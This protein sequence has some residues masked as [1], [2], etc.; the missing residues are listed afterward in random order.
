[1]KT[2]TCLVLSLAL[3]IQM[4]FSQQN[5]IKTVTSKSGTVLKYHKN[6]G[7]KIIKDGK[8]SFKDLNKNGKLDA[9]EDWRLPVEERAKDLASKMSVEQI[10]GLM[11][12]S[13]HQSIPSGEVGFGAGTYNGKPFSES[14][15]EA[16]A[17]SDQ[18]KQ[19]LKDDNLRHV[20]LTAVKS[21]EVAAKWNNNVQAYVEGLG[22]GI[23]ANN[24]SD[25]RN[26]AE[27][28]SEFNAGAGGTIS[29]WP[30]GLAMGATFDPELVKQF[31]EMASK[32]YRALGITTALSPQVDLGTEPRW[33]RI[34]YVFSESPELVKAMG[35]AYIEGFQTS[36]K[37]SEINSGW[38]YQ[39]VN[40]MVKHWP[41]GGPEE[42]GR[43][44]HWAMGKFAVYPGDNFSDHLKPFTEGAFKLDGGTEKASAVMP[45][46]TISFDRDDVYKENVGN[47]FS[48]YMIT[49]LLRDQYGYDGVVCTDWLITSDEGATPATFAGKPWGTEELSIA[50]RHYKVLK[51]GVD[52]FG[53]NNE[54][55]PVLEA[56]QMGVEEFG[57]DYMRKRFERSAVRLLKNI[58]R[59]GLFEN[60]Y[61]DVE[62]TKAIVG[63]AEFMKAGYK[64]QV[65]SVVMLKNKNQVLPIKEKQTVYIPKIYT[66]VATDWW[67]NAT[68]AH[69]DYPVDIDL[70]KKYYK[71]TEDPKKADFAL[72]FVRNP[73]TKEAGYSEVDR[74]EG[75]NGYVP[76]SLQYETYTATTAREHSIAAGD[77]VIDPEIKDRSYKGKSS[78][79]SYIMD[80]RTI[81]D[82]KMLMGDKPVIVSVTAN[83]PM[84]FSEFES[85][86]DGIVLNF[87]VST[88]AVLDIVSGKDEP[89]GLLPV[90]MPANMET[91]EAQQE[92]VPFDMIPYEDSEGNTYDFGYGLDWN[93]VIKDERVTK[94]KK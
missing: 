31:G 45:Y 34:A 7:V 72:V 3:G 66:P 40:A 87:G 17:I 5:D 36:D 23:P 76:I 49:E 22:L 90:Q 68:E 24:S 47:G 55:G 81:E 93:G 37:D 85:Q 53:G 59:T 77:P 38:G 28:T 13:Q 58:F 63:N 2:K 92:D 69:F 14:G 44:A 75:G 29:L 51:A 26:T 54:K 48:K 94:Y 4:G 41:G 12:Y 82:T 30:D 50:E 86:V 6:S 61:V 65:K 10:A 64:A 16:S 60:P 20:L 33:Y 57:E 79:S 1:M 8:E 18:Q 39:S 71:V 80:L 67:G 73:Q 19:F 62:E 78:T 88:Q 15:A 91:V 84:I 27:V 70:I 43:D 35:K 46:Y 52:Q 74:K 25:P 32:E 11:L 83:K 21:P 56:Y 42:G 9:Y 89:S